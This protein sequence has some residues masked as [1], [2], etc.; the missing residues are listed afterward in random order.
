MNSLHQW[1]EKGE[2]PLWPNG[3]PGDEIEGAPSP[4]IRAFPPSGKP[5]GAS[6]IV[7]PGGGYQA[8]ADHEAYPIAQW[9]NG[10]GI[11][12]FV[13]NYRLSPH[14]HHPSMLQD[15]ALAIRTVRAHAVEWGLSPDRIG[16]L[17]FSAGGHLASTIATHF[18]Q[19]DP[20]SGDIILRASSRPDMAILIYPVISLISEH[21]HYGSRENLLGLNPAPDIAESLSAERQVTAETPPIFLVHGADDTAVPVENSL[22]LAMAL[23][24][25]K[26]PFELHIYEQ[27]EHGFGLGKGVPFVND[28]TGRCER[29]MAERGFLAPRTAA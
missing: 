24:R 26:V 25:S 1:A 3:Y 4:S 28:W 13:L 11:T 21:T 23:S 2:R 15:A 29:W 17:G 16:I 27:G 5:N 18:D 20:H 6:V 10:L 7:C 8:L 19:G 14:F 9:L 22:A 12:G